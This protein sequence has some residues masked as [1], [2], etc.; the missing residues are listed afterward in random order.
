VHTIETNI[1]GTE[2]VL[3]VANKFRKN[4]LLASSSEVYERARK[5]RFARTTTRFWI[6]PLLAVVLRLL[7][8]HR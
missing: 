6:D 4:V 3:A 8:G 1:H 5:S 2:V 7:E